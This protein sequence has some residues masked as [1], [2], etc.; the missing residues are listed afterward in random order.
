MIEMRGLQLGQGRKIL[1][2]GR[3]FLGKK[4]WPKIEIIALKAQP[5]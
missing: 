5:K 2:Q 3:K 4:T 1:A